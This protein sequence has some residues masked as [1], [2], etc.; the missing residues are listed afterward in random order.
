MSDS[1][2][3][4]WFGQSVNRDAE[5]ADEVAEVYGE[6]DAAEYEFER[7]ATGRREQEARHGESIDPD[8]GR[9]AYTYSQ[10]ASDPDAEHD[11]RVSTVPLDTDDGDQVVIEQQNVGPGRQV[12]AGEFKEDEDTSFHKSPEAAAAEQERLDD[13]APVD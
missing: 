10:D 11:P 9:S 5:V 3:E 13:E 8:Q 12:G 2:V 6:G 4:D 7:R 1:R